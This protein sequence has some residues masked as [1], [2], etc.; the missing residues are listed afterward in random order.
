[1]PNRRQARLNEQLKREISRIVRRELSDPRIRSV[2][3]TGAEVTSDLAHAKV[4]IRTLRTDSDVEQALEGLRAAAPR[5]RRDLGKELHLRRVPELHFE[6]DRTLERAMR[7]ERLLDEVRPEG[8]WE[9]EGE[10][11]DGGDGESF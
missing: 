10:P 3:V 8:G 11:G 9:D 4:F 6:E 7:I 2:T 5:V 1:M